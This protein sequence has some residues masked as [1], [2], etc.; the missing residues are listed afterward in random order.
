MKKYIM[1]VLVALLTVGTSIVAQNQRS[2]TIQAETVVIQATPKERATRLAKQLKLP[3]S[4]IYTLENYFAKVDFKRDVVRADLKRDGL[5][6][7]DRKAKLEELRAEEDADLSS[8]IGSEKMEEYIKFR[9]K[10]ESRKDVGPGEKI[11]VN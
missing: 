8:I 3:N 7:D 6:G 1:L 4:Q 11:K 5:N 9:I 10:R 2:K